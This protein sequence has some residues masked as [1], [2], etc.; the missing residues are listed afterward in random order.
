MIHCIRL[1]HGDRR[2]ERVG[3][4]SQEMAEGKAE[5]KACEEARDRRGARQGKV[6]SNT[7][8]QHDGLIRSIDE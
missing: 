6:C 2:R 3:A 7:V 8:D 1:I 4:E 5:G